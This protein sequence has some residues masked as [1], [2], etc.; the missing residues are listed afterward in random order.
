MAPSA[1][2][3]YTVT[4]VAGAL[5]TDPEEPARGARVWLP[6]DDP[7]ALLRDYSSQRTAARRLLRGCR[8]LAL[9]GLQ[10]RT[11]SASTLAV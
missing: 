3:R 11:S 8:Q 7:A 2:G 10:P 1:S 6:F 4:Q 5:I 9:Y